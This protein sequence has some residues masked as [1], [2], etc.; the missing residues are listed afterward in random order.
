M[1]VYL[2]SKFFLISG[3]AR[4]AGHSETSTSQAMFRGQERTCLFKSAH[5]EEGWFLWPSREE[6]ANSS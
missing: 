5:I 2:S 3:F 4:C 6:N 1:D